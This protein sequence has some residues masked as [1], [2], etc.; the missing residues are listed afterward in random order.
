MQP[1]ALRALDFDRIREAL[2]REALTPFGRESALAIEPSSDA[3]DVRAR[4]AL[5]A[6]AMRYLRDGGSLSIAA[7]DQLPAALMALDVEGQPLAPTQ[8][9]AVAS[10]V[11]AIEDVA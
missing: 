5:A 7:S 2:A 10:F 8:L 11:E 6:E 1:A 9:L 4:L 3:D